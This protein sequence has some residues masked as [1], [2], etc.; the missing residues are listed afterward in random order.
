MEL[1]QIGRKVFLDRYAQKGNRETLAANDKVMVL[2]KPDPKWP[3]VEEAS[4]TDVGDETVDVELLTGEEV[5]CIK[6]Y[7]IG[8][9]DKLIETDPEQ[10]WE[11]VARGLAKDN[12]DYQDF[13]KVL[14]GGYFVPAGRILAA[15]GT[16]QN[17][18]LYNC[19]LV[20]LPTDSRS[21]IINTLRI[22]VELMSRGAGVGINI[23][24]LRPQYAP[25]FGV[26]GRSSGAVSWG[27]L[28]SYAT[29][30]VSQG[31]CFAGDVRITTDK[32]LIPAKELFFKMS[33]G[34]TF[35]ALTHAGTKRLVNHFDNGI[36]PVYKVT[37]ANGFNVKV[38]S[39]HRMGV[40]RKGKIATVTLDDLAI[41]DTM[42]LSLSK[43]VNLEHV[44][45]KP[46]IYERSVMSTTL[47]ENVLLPEVLNE[48]LA[49]WLGYSFG[50]GYVQ[51]DCETQKG[52]VFSVSDS[53]KE[54]Q[55]EL[56]SLT[57]LLFG[58]DATCNKQKDSAS[59]NVYVYSR[60]LIEWLA[61]NGLLK[62]KAINIRLPEAI[63]RSPSSVMGAFVAGYFDADGSDRKKKGGYGFDSISYDMLTDI[64]Q[65][66]AVNGIV[67]HIDT[68]KRNGN[69]RDIHRLIITGKVFKQRFRDF[70]SPYSLKDTKTPSSNDYTVAYSNEE[71]DALD[72]PNKYYKG[73]WAKSNKISYNALTRIRTNLINDNQ[74]EMAARIGQLLNVVPD[75]ITN[76]E[77]IGEENVY[78]FEVEDV[79]MLSGNGIY[80]SNSRRGALLLLLSDWH[81]DIESFIDVKRIAGKMENANI[82]VGISTQFE[83]A[84][85]NDDWWTLEFPD[86]KH[87]RYG[88]EW[89]GDLWRWKDRGY[90]T[91]VYKR[92]RARELWRKITQSAWACAEPGLVR[93]GYN[94]EMSNSWYFNQ[95]MGVNPCAEEPLP[96]WGV[97]DLGHINLGRM[98]KGTDV[99]W[100]RL[101]D[102]IH[103]AIRALD[104]V[105]DVT[106]YFFDEQREQ[107]K[108]E[109]RIGLGTLGL[110]E[111]LVRLGIANDGQVPPDTF[112]YG[113]KRCLVFID[114]LYRFIAEEAYSASIALADKYG[115]FPAFDADKFIESGFMKNM[116]DNIRTAVH[117]HG[118]RN[119][120]VLTQAPTGSVGT[121]MGTSTGIE[122]YYSWKY[123]RNSRLG[124]VEVLEGVASEWLSNHPNK[125]V[126]DLPPYFVTA[127]ELTPEEHIH[128]QAAI[129][130]WTD[131]AISKTVNMP[132][133]ATIADVEKV[134]QLMIDLGIKGGTIYRD[135][136]RNE[137]VLT[138]SVDTATT[139]TVITEDDVTN[140]CPNGSCSL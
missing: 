100:D 11:R 133:N 102:T 24:S 109:R 72:V 99:D 49:Y 56:V 39:E 86:T 20:P 34:E 74:T 108:K 127:M 101:K 126:H 138:A 67:S 28:Y 6:T 62:D 7:P 12:L 93:L 131:A 53:R 92:M 117:D 105:I 139:A 44:K 21:G 80:T 137:Q 35:S 66:L 118:I 121:M 84:L 54:I 65:V 15:A 120:C 132:H 130:K 42:L 87:P 81:P 52:L 88:S 98:V 10:V 1:G 4:V 68:Q 79:H 73:V 31:G 106:P 64:Q 19:N 48:N 76:I 71:W 41:G 82:S 9:V 18:T 38:T 61:Q 140:D 51:M 2:V 25:V 43:N 57:K 70:I 26:N 3:Q 89:N 13:K 77:L 55:E 58:L 94:N 22:M 128:M 36:K 5:G 45:L 17:L 33:N 112:R 27:G 14:S 91:L 97:C 125:T 50:N 90:P 40:L 47:N 16:D 59:T 104:N 23:S 113:S 119:V 116:P 115:S 60:I 136:S 95:I 96:P 75:T 69:W 123:F 110:A 114:K 107:A 122:P 124:L 63:F 111:L 129:Q 135:G 78:D 29:G 32:G 83:K 37:T 85:I 103:I 8:R 46:V 134:Y 30:L